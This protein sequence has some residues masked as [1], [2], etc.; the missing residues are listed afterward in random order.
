MTEFL[1]ALV[2][3][4]RKSPRRPAVFDSEI[5]R[6]V[7][8][9]RLA[10]PVPTD[11]ILGAFSNHIDFQNATSVLVPLHEAD[12]PEL[13][14]EFLEFQTDASSPGV[15]F[16]DFSVDDFTKIPTY[17]FSSTYPAWRIRFW[18]P[19]Y[20]AETTPSFLYETA[21]TSDSLV[22]TEGVSDIKPISSQGDD[23]FRELRSFI[24]TERE[25]ERTAHRDQYERLSIDTYC[26]HNDGIPYLTPEEMEIDEYGQQAVVLRLHSPDDHEGYPRSLDLTDEFGVHI[27]DEVI[28]D[29]RGG[30][31]GFPV[32]AEFLGIEGH[33]VHLGVY[34]NRIPHTTSAEEVF[35][36][37]GDRVFCLGHLLNP[38][39][40]DRELE[41]VN[42]IE[43]TERKRAILTGAESPEFETT[44]SQTV[45]EARLNSFQYQAAQQSIRAEDVY[46]IHGPPGTGKTRTLVEIIVSL[47]KDGCRV[48][49]CA[50]SNQAVDNLLVGESTEDF[51]DR[52]S[53]HHAAREG[54][55]SVARVGHH[56]TTPLVN[57]QYSE[58][59]RYQSDVVC[60]TTSGA[61]AFGEDIFDYAILDEAT[62]ASIPASSIP[63]SRAETMILAGDHKQLPPYSASEHDEAEMFEISMF[64]QLLERFTGG[65]TTTLR[66]QYRMN[67]A[68]AAV[69][70]EMFYEG[71]LKHG[72]RNRTWTAGPLAPLEAYDIRGNE[73]QTPSKSYYNETEVDI[74]TDEVQRLLDTGITA[75]EIGIIS[76]YSGQVGKITAG[77]TS[78]TGDTDALQVSTIDAFQGSER[79]AIIVSV[80]RSNDQGYSGFLTFPEIGPRRLNVALT[81]AKR[82]LVLVGDFTTLS[83]CGPDKSQEQSAADVYGE[84]RGYLKDYGALSSH[85]V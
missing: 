19:D 13:T 54:E 52:S 76:P 56:S 51:V 26:V 46:C 75:E 49:A 84:L 32:E 6:H 72:S 30:E 85:P 34:W 53:L 59:D 3:A 80:V 8:L 66:T 27:E 28:V 10:E 82:R 39:T 78:V 20:S 55:I 77:L 37:P 45:R 22:P 24:E 33:S 38:I 71:A 9:W 83:T 35:S 61:A 18:H 41:A 23:F 21:E 17:T 58:N 15:V 25:A 16:Y 1:D 68:I 42:T 48:L 11:E 74:V 7:G 62:Q 47:A 40:Y 81:R 63:F 29:V 14:G 2:R 73:Q 65:I 12:S 44:R 69:P 50:H 79:E 70:N 67:K 4:F 5:R 64:E 31:D 43:E 36:S 60:A 57:D